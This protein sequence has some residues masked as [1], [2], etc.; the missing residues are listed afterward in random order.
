[1][2]PKRKPAPFG[3]LHRDY[4]ESLQAVLIAAGILEATLTSLMNTKSVP[5]SVRPMVAKSLADYRR[6]W[7]GDG[8]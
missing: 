5:E 2:P 8:T 7:D 4:D 6:A 1:M 3:P